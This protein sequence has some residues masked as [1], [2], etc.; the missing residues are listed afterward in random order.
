MLWPL[1]P[2][3]VPIYGANPIYHVP[4]PPNLV[5]CTNVARYCP[6][7]SSP[8]HLHCCFCSLQEQ[9]ALCFLQ[10]ICPQTIDDF[11]CDVPPIVCPPPTCTAVA[12]ACKNNGCCVNAPKS[13]ALSVMVVWPLGAGPLRA[14]FRWKTRAP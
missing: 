5:H 4:V 7:P 10:I 2:G 6:T 1:V 13:L 14:T 12:A 9:R 8:T 3:I 11:D